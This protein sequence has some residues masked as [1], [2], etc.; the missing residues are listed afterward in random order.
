MNKYKFFIAVSV[1]PFSPVFAQ[2]MDKNSNSSLPENTIAEE[3]SGI[4]KGVESSTPPL[5]LPSTT[6]EVNNPPVEQ[7]KKIDINHPNDVLVTNS[8]TN[9]DKV[10]NIDPLSLDL[11]KTKYR[12]IFDLK[13]NNNFIVN[14]TVL[15]FEKNHLLI[16]KKFLISL[17]NELENPKFYTINKKE[18]FY[19]PAQF[20]NK[21]DLETLKIDITLSPDYFK[22]QSI[23]LDSQKE[24]KAE[25]ITALYVN[26]NLT[27][28]FDANKDLT[29]SFSTGL[30]HK[31]NWLIKSNFVM[32]SDKK[33]TRG[34]TSFIYELPSKSRLIVGDTFGNS[35]NNFS[36]GNFLGARLSSPYYANSIDNKE[37][38][39]TV[40]V[41]GYSLNPSKL[42]IFVNDRLYQSKEVT[43][44]KYNINVPLLNE[45]GLGNVRAVVYDKAG[46]PI[47]VEFPFFADSAIL[48]EGTFEYDISGGFMRKAD[49]KWFSYDYGQPIINALMTYGVNDR[50]TQQLYAQ[51]TKDYQAISGTANFIPFVGL[52]KVSASLSVNNS[53]ETLGNLM[54]S[55][56]H[57]YFSYGINYTSALNG[58]MFCNAFSYSCIKD[59]LQIYSGFKLPASLGS[60]NLT[61]AK[62]NNWNKTVDTLSWLPSQNEVAT[63]SYSKN[64]VGGLSLNANISKTKGSSIKGKGVTA[65]VGLSYSFGRGIS[66]S[67]SVSNNG[68]ANTYQQ[69]MSINE[70]PDKPWLGYGGFTTNKTGNSEL[71]TNFFY[72]ANMN[73]FSYNINGTQSNSGGVSASGNISGAMY[74]LPDKMKVGLSKEIT[75]GLAVVEVQNANKTPIPISYENKL[76]GYTDKEGIFVVPNISA[77][78]LETIS[79]DVNKMPYN[80]SLLEHTRSYRIPSNGS[81]KFIFR[82]RTNPYLV[83]L[84]GLP[85]GYVFKL[86]DD[87]YAVGEQGKTTLETEGNAKIE[88]A[89]GKFCEINFSSDV[90]SYYCG[91]D[92]QELDNIL[93]SFSKSTMKPERK[94][95]LIKRDYEKLM[96]Q[97]GKKPQEGYI[98]TIHQFVVPVTNLDRSNSNNSSTNSTEDKKEIKEDNES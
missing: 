75:S 87:Y 29:G 78:N 77:N 44:G 21:V 59:S 47:V 25:P 54:Y 96:T 36:S 27:S 6:S 48:K 85:S 32:D 91:V 11:K 40:N 17:L 28:N 24:I 22:P 67:T 14:G 34:D 15:V 90:K 52:G 58:S 68:G 5:T 1:L 49:N 82:A 38:L 42:D 79:V 10:P 39:P 88:Y 94:E 37:L 72:S 43:A 7:I 41:N 73:N 46:N 84:Y 60:L 89:E 2:E 98:S 8:Q 55:R 62:N 51:A 71:N 19:I 81:A 69:Q 33:F 31:D 50:W 86:G 64:I 45:S 26:Y 74:F 23:E 70:N 93:N 65:Y 80:V 92:G 57:E 95:E 53:G 3:K 13:I 30:M 61:Y 63:L 18:Y 4:K 12:E 66:G 76:A 16:E 97:L 20:V 9:P 83:R 56:S 35:I